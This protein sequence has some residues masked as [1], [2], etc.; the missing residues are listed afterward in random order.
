MSTRDLAQRQHGRLAEEALLAVHHLLGDAA[1]AAAVSARL[2]GDAARARVAD[3]AGALLVQRRRRRA[4]RHRRRVLSLQRGD[5]RLQRRHLR[6][7][8][9]LLVCHNSEHAHEHVTKIR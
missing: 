5:Q 1:V 3:P 2:E 7:R 6:A 4:R 9:L 8:Q